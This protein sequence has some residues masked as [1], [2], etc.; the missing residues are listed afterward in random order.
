MYGIFRHK[1]NLY[2]LQLDWISPA[3]FLM[4]YEV[5]EIKENYIIESKFKR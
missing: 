1:K 5:K 3:I 4:R 2:C